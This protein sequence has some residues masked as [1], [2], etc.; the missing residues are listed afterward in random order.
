MGVT[1]QDGAMQVEGIEDAADLL[2]GGG[3]AGVDVGAALGLAGSGEIKSDDV[4]VGVELQ[5]EGDEGSG[6]TH[7]AVEQNDRG[8]ILGRFTLFEVRE[9]KAVE[10]NMLAL[11]HLFCDYPGGF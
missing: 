4:L 10:L 1:E 5:H 3:E 6:A 9:A 2:G 7:E 8:L 11:N